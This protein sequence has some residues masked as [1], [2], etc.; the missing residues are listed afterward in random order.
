MEEVVEK[1]YSDFIA[2]C[3]PFIREPS[4]VR[5]IM[6]KKTDAASCTSCNKCLAA[7]ANDIPVRCHVDGF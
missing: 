7:V 2:I 3:R 4:Q 6:N 1:G 5:K